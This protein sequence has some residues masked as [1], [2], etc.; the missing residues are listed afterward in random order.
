MSAHRFAT[1]CVVIAAVV[2]AATP[3][4]AQDRL[5]GVL[6]NYST[7]EERPAEDGSTRTPA[8]STRHSFK[9]A[10]L[11]S[12]DPVVFPYVGLMTAFNGNRDSSYGD[13]YLRAFADNSIGNFMTAAVVPSL[14]NEDSRYF[15]SGEGGVFRRFA[16]AAS[17]SVVT[18]T[19]SGRATF[20]VSEVGG[21]LAAAGLSNLY[22]D[23]A[24]R[25]FGGTMSRWGLQVMGDTLGN[26]LKEFWPD[27]HAKLRRNR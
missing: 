24:D 5:F 15:R 27:I 3:A 10:S 25:T 14:T 23:P 6:P 13:R 20:N 9:I 22:H 18:R 11:N 2:C 19:R 8:I 16:Y 1:G 26:E 12:F 4:F 21:N 17:R 7:V